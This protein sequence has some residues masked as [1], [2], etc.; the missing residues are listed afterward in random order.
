MDDSFARPIPVQ[1]CPPGHV[2]IESR[3]HNMHALGD[4]LAARPAANSENPRDRIGFLGAVRSDPSLE[5]IDLGRRYYSS[6]F[7]TKPV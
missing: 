1:W 3:F 2:R 4:G 5:F 6:I 7:D